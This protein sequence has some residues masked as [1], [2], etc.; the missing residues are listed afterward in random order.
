MRSRKDINGLEIQVGDHLYVAL[1]CGRSA[2]LEKR[3][4]TGFTEDGRIKVEAPKKYIWSRGTGILQF[5]TK[6]LV[7]LNMRSVP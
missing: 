1:L 4:V 7:D 2:T 3:I 6:T 5:S